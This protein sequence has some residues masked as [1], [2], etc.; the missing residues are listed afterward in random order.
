M[1]ADSSTAT[2]TPADDGANT[3]PSPWAQVVRVGIDPNSI[4]PIP[5]PEVAERLP[6]F[7]DPVESPLESSDAGN[8]CNA[9]GVTR[10]AWSRPSANGGVDGT[11]SPVMGAA[12]W[13]ALSESTRS[14]VKSV[15]GSS[16][17][18][19]KPA[20]DG[21]AGASQA[22]VISQPPLK[23]VK[24]TSNSHSNQNHV[25]QRSFRRGGGAGASAGYSRPLQPPPL[26][27]PFPLVDMY[28]NLVPAVPVSPQ[29][30][31]KANNWSPRPVDSRHP[32]RRN[33]FGPRPI[34][35]G[36]GGRREHHGPRT[37][38][39]A[40]RDVH[41]PHQMAPSPPPPYRGFGRPPFFLPRPLRPYGPPTGYEMG[42][43]YVYFPT[44]AQAPYRGGAPVFSHGAVASSMSMTSTDY[45][46]HDEIVKQ[47]EYYFS[48]D[49]LVKDNFLR[50]HMDEEGWVPITLIAGFPR[51]QA[52][53]S[54]IQ[55][56]LS[57]LR[58][59]TAVEI[60][61][62]KVRR[63]AD[64]RKWIHTPRELTEKFVEEAS[65]QKLTLVDQPTNEEQVLANGDVSI[66]Y[67][68]S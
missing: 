25:R 4:S 51:V 59:S 3:L 17:D 24:H 34:N 29:P 68:C 61:G 2:I 33:N 27:P 38:G 6:V 66:E 7:S 26:P 23:Q 44:L 49:N 1:T 28:G 46:L 12:S 62:D 16:E 9:A 37:N 21:S 63:R 39:P 53:S 20:S 40:A 67:H 60:Q 14:G 52:L 58:D 36:F 31:F 15:S 48:D 64:W 30:P 13:P 42:G 41:V 43:S 22:P 5:S 56:L 57:F 18:S 35:N 50:S 19:S 11:S 8:N 55:M 45:S 47:I 65:L 54:D 32:G 10:S